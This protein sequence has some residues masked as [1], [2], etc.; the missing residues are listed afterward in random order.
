MFT[1]A[2]KKLTTKAA[3]MSLQQR[4]EQLGREIQALDRAA[5]ASEA[6]FGAIS[7]GSDRATLLRHQGEA[8]VHVRNRLS[9]QWAITRVRLAIPEAQTLAS[10]RAGEAAAAVASAEERCADLK[11]KITGRLATRNQLLE[12]IGAVVSSSVAPVETARAE[13][14][15]ASEEGDE[16]A[17]ERAS[18]AL[19]KA[20]NGK[21]AADGDIA[22]MR[23]QIEAHDR[24]I[25]RLDAA[26]QGEK[27]A[28]AEAQAKQRA[29]AREI[30][31]LTLDEGC[32]ALK[33]KAL[34][35]GQAGGEEVRSIQV[36]FG[37]S[38]TLKEIDAEAVKMLAAYT[39]QSLMVHGRP[40]V[41][42]AKLDVDPASLSD[43]VERGRETKARVLQG[44]EA[45]AALVA[46]AGDEGDPDA[47]GEMLEDARADQIAAELREAGFSYGVTRSVP[48]EGG[49][50]I[51]GQG[52][53][54]G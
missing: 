32:V 54:G 12:R 41:H 13:L 52:Q 20:L 49:V 3:E 47:G 21:T 15:K 50:T 29:A 38:S 6:R 30:A 42:E 9:G 16:A 40:H 34:D 37:F 44:D 51:T 39:V 22:P 27:Q 17:I 11:A 43:R 19:T 45:D 53:Q 35:Y 28:L 24:V 8:R 25:E 4:A 36:P 23:V 46:E 26:L 2:L 48:E 7:N 33:E 1:N 14:S 5:E 18:A 10:K 31:A